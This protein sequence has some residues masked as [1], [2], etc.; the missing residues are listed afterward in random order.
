M[1]FLNAL[2]T[3]WPTLLKGLTVTLSLTALTLVF[4]VVL[5]AIIV[6][7][8]MS[9]IRAL[10]AFATA[11]LAIVRGVPL[12]AL[13]FVIYFGIVSIVKVDAFAAA[14][15]G[16][17]VHSS[18]Y[19]AEIFRSGINSVHNGQIEAS[20]SLGMSRVA[21][22]SKVVAPQALRVVVPALVNQAIISLKD[23]AVA[24]F[25][26]VDELFMSAQRLSAATF[27]PLTYYAI[28]SLYYLAI[29]GAMTYFS[30]RVER[31]FEKRG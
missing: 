24:S 9:K 17:S 21:T 26:T 11:Y 7:L 29:V 28:V 14:A 13:L 25:I 5:G 22:M 27:Q 18:A 31:Y 12:I 2:I 19:V 6:A 10:S 8:K 30:G 16:L 15:I 23:S 4:S 1:E 3:S 20:R